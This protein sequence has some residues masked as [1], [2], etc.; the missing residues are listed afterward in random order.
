MTEEILVGYVNNFEFKDEATKN[1]LN[2][3]PI[4]GRVYQIIKIDGVYYIQIG[5][6]KTQGML[7][8]ITLG[9]SLSGTYGDKWNYDVIP[10]TKDN[11]IDFTLN[12][13]DYENV[14]KWLDTDHQDLRNKVNG[15][16]TPVIV[17]EGPGNRGYQPISQEEEDKLRTAIQATL[18]K[19]FPITKDII[20]RISS[21]LNFLVDN[22]PHLL[23]AVAD[24]LDYQV[25]VT[26]ESKADTPRDFI[27]KDYL[28]YSISPEVAMFN[29]LTGVNYYTHTLDKN[30]LY[31]AIEYSLLELQ[32]RKLM[33]T[34]E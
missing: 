29:V 28:L 27:A 13:E 4:V 18:A 10:L 2:G 11:Y 19:H 8:G 34:N 6:E 20:S 30:D 14:E 3:H 23:E 16:V 33:D 5:A 24:Y 1:N 17:S 22:D 32:R 26:K 12:Q 15:V 25:Q 21:S 7:D 31:S 9:E